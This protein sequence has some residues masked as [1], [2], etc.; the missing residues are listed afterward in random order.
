[1]DSSSDPFAGFNPLDFAGTG[2]T[3]GTPTDFGAGMNGVGVGPQADGT[4]SYPDAAQPSNQP[5]DVGGTASGNYGQTV[6]DTLKFG[7]GVW[8]QQN[9]Q[10]AFYDYKR[11]EATNGGLFQYGRFAGMNGVPLRVNPAKSGTLLVLLA[12]GAILLIKA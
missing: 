4:Y 6:L 12:L 8:Q 7:V 9:K 5:W 1:M 3:G 10:N 2:E 11:F